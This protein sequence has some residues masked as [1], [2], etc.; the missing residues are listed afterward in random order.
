MLCSDVCRRKRLSIER[1]PKE[2]N[3]CICGKLYKPYRN[4]KN[5]LCSKKCKDSKYYIE[6]KNI[7]KQKR[8]EYHWDNKEIIIKKQKEKYQKNKDYYR[9]KQKEYNIKNKE[10][11]SIQKKIYREKEENKNHRR[12]YSKRRYKKELN[13]KLR[14]ILSRRLYHAIK[15]GKKTK[16][17]LELI[18]CSIDYLR[19]YLENQFKEGMKWDNHGHKGWHIDHIK[20]CSSFDLRDLKQQEE[21]FHYTNL[22][23]LWWWEN[24]SKSN[25]IDWESI[26]G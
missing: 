26:E 9:I 6:N 10:T 7:I 5:P 20:P 12:E 17:T 15:N 25:K 16:P 19:I 13:F 23:P 11:I 8:K 1:S 24:L 18:G 21:C 22:Q 4:V 3:C 14:H 2:T